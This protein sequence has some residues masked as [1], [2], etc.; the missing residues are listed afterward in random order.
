MPRL[1][2]LEWCKICKRIQPMKEH[3]C[4]DRDGEL[5]KLKQWVKEFKKR[6]KIN[7]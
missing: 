5:K 2:N 1:P 6:K 3:G 7:N 4:W